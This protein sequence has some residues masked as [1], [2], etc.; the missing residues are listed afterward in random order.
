MK[1]ENSVAVVTGANRGLGLAFAKAL[2]E[3]GAKKVYAGARQPSSVTLPGVIPVELDVTRPETIAAFAA[4]AG[5]VTLVINNAGIAKGGGVLSNDAVEKARAEIETNYLG[6]L[7]TSQAFAPILAKNGGGAIVNVLSALSWVTLPQ[8]STY[9]A[10]KSAAWALTNG[11]RNELRP[12]NT[13]VLGVHLGFTDTDMA[14]HVAAPKSRPE[15]I[16]RHALDA[17][18]AGQDEALADAVSQTIKQNLSGGVYL[19][20][21]RS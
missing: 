5:D 12:Q 15:D 21:W 11:L 13:H 10:S 6:P 3:R 2:L 14:R 8:T 19:D 7:V 9:S 4:V 18:E 16:V 1:I 20:A 17:L